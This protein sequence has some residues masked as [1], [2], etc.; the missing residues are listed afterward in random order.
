MI[1]KAW[2]A[3]SAS[4]AALVGVGLSA[5]AIAQISPSQDAYAGSVG[6]VTVYA[7]HRWVRQPTTGRWVRADTLSV[8][9]SLADLDLSTGFGAREAK[10]RI[11]DAARDVCHEVEDAYPNDVQGPGNCYV[12]AL[13]EGLDQTQDMAGYP[14]VAWGYR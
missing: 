6:G 3:A 10:R 11:S 7:P 13:R 4:V 12:E 14:I 2:I 9:V 5:P 8:R 1:A